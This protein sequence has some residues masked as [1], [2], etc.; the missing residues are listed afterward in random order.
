M[1]DY[2]WIIHVT[3]KCFVIFVLSG[4]NIQW[5]TN[6]VWQCHIWVCQSKPRCAFTTNWD[7]NVF[8][9]QK[10]GDNY[11]RKAAQNYKTA[12][13]FDAYV[14]ENYNIIFRGVLL[15]LLLPNSTVFNHFAFMR[16]TCKIIHAGVMMC[17]HACRNALVSHTN[18]WMLL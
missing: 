13:K 9:S 3:S 1:N 5:Y 7:A 16:I 8:Y 10:M 17:V 12:S 15:K 2:Q 18:M 6:I 11:S 4:F 14:N